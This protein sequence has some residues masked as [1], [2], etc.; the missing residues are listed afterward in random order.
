MLTEMKDAK[1]LL[2]TNP[3]FLDTETTGFRDLDEVIEISIIDMS[4]ETLFSSLVK[5]RIPIPPD[6]MRVHGITDQMVADA[7]IWTDIYPEVKTVFQGKMIGMYNAKFDLRMMQQ[8]SALSGIVWEETYAD[9]F[10]VMEMYAEYKGV[11]VPGR[12]GFKWQKLEQAGRDL[13]ISIPNS[14]RSLDDT[15]LTKEVFRRIAQG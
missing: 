8:S 14:H 9:I 12:S 6:A 11:R 15:L 1:R 2:A 10:C 5:P 4:G 3:I 7:P 13:K